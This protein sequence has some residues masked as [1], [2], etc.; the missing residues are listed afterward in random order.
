MQPGR[1]RVHDPW[2]LHWRSPA[3]APGHGISRAGERDADGDGVGDADRDI[4]DDRDGDVD[5]DAVPPTAGALPWLP[6]P[7]AVPLT[8]PV[9]LALMEGE[10][11]AEA[12]EDADADTGGAPSHASPVNPVPPQSH[13]APAGPTTQVPGPHSMASHAV[14]C[15]SITASCIVFSTSR[16]EAAASKPPLPAGWAAVRML[17]ALSS[18]AAPASASASSALPLA[19]VLSLLL[20][21]P[22][23]LAGARPPPAGRNC[24]SRE[25]RVG[26]DSVT[27][28]LVPATASHPATLR[29]AA[30]SVTVPAASAR[31]SGS[32]TPATDEALEYTVMADVEPSAP[33][34]NTRC[35][36]DAPGVASVHPVDVSVNLVAWGAVG[37]GGGAKGGY[38]YEPGGARQALD[39]AQ[40]ARPRRKALPLVHMWP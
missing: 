39:I 31:D 18:S 8:L 26:A 10:A 38:I 36:S 32:T 29:A 22:L 25:A 30:V 23:E 35:D 21:P 7:L 12:E 27:V 37:G 19:L 28:A 16:A 4:D 15:S 2:P 33:H 5:P 17:S 24:A 13:A 1:E 34:A 9:A 3:P 6:L 11:V 14:T 40:N 20:L